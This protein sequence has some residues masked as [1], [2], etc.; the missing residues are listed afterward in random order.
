[1]RLILG[2][3]IAFMPMAAYAAYRRQ[4]TGADAA[5]LPFD[6]ET[7]SEPPSFLESTGIIDMIKTRGER[8]N[9]PGNIVK[10]PAWQGLAADQIDTRFASFNDPSYGIRAMAVLLKNYSA[11]G[12][13]TVRKIINRYAPSS[14]NNTAAYISSV[15]YGIGKGADD[16]LNLNDP[17]LLQKLVTAIIRHENGRVIYSDAQ[18]QQAIGLA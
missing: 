11:Q 6:F 18:I 14:E 12:Y 7:I 13:N 4:N 2:F 3:L 10:G 8:N 15:A 5:V 16:V 9:N 17:V 1:M